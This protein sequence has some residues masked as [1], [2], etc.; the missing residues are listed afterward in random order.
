MIGRCD[1]LPG[2]CDT[3]MKNALEWRKCSGIAVQLTNL[4]ELFMPYIIL[5]P[6][7]WVHRPL[8]TRLEHSWTARTMT[9]AT[10]TSR[11]VPPNDGSPLSGR[12][13]PA[14]PAISFVVPVYGSP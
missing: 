10:T 12:N 6:A 5:N 3:T 14:H 8:R 7:Y 1:T 4:R 13:S 11:V 9:D 2:S